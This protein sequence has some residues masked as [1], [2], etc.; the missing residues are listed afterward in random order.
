[1][2]NKDHASS[3]YKGVHWAKKAKAFIARICHD[4]K[5]ELVGSFAK[6][7]DA[8]IAYN[9][10]A[11][12]LF[13]NNAVLNDVPNWEK[14]AVYKLQQPKNTSQ[15][16]GVY[17]CKLNNKYAAHITVANIQ[18]NLGYFK[19]EVDAAIAYNQKA[20]ALLGEKAI[21]NDLQNINWEKI[22]IQKAREI[23]RGHSNKSSSYFGVYFNNN[24]KIYETKIMHQRKNYFLG[25]FVDEIDAALA[26]NKKAIELRGNKAILNKIV[27]KGGADDS[28]EFCT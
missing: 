6:E 13:G 12:E 26:Y 22:N 17:L 16:I 20:K 3:K 10:R 1:M 2:R 21:L 18:Y 23:D 11:K 9:Q 19:N 14:T 4:G 25:R 8:A 27:R 7:T 24:L 5:S 15:Y 28:H